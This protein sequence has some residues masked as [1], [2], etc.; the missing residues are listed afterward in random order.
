MNILIKIITLNPEAANVQELK[1]QLAEQGLEPTCFS[2]IDGRKGMPE[3]EQDESI[4]QAQ[5]LKMNLIQ[6]TPA[7]VGCYLSHLRA[8]KEACAAGTQKLCILEDDVL[9]ENSF[10]SILSAIAKL[11]DDVEFVR[12]I[13]T[14]DN[15]RPDVILIRHSDLITNQTLAE[16]KKLLPHVPLVYRNLDPLWR[17]RDIKVI[18]WR[19]KVM[20]AIFITT[21]GEPLKQFCTGKNVVAYIPNAT[22][23][24]M[25]D[26]DNSQKTE[27]ERDLMF[28][29]RGD[30][31]DDRYAF[32]Q[33][34]D[35][36]L[37]QKLSF[38][39]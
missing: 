25:D 36:K 19:K 2:G 37:K 10:G 8:I 15:F 39:A 21:G 17:E 16:V 27:F 35:E 6:M 3:L 12:L 14:C 26:Q 5:S 22:D 7:E 9:I 31:T 24:G 1:R 30:K 28:V 34:I 33:R 23:P 18:H 20:D 11:P 29:G 4:N 38:E 32:L 13:E